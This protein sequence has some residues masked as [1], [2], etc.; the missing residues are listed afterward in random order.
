MAAE[1]G[2]KEE[3][4]SVRLP[5]HE[6]RLTPAQQGTIDAFL[7][8]LAQNPYSPPTDQIPAPDLLNLL[9]ERR[10]VIKVSE[11]TVFAAKAFDAIVA[12]VVNLINSNGKVTLAE[13]RD[14]LKTTRKYAQPLLEHMDEKKI[15]RRVGDDRVL[16]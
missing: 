12:G 2:L 5:S 9:I 10:Q 11:G 14:M 3:G 6:V 4:L 13:V 7:R 1:G 15:T 16:Y 8:S